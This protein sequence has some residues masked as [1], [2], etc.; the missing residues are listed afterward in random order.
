MEKSVRIYGEY[1]VLQ[2]K[3]VQ[4]GYGRIIFIWISFRLI[5]VSVVT[6][7]NISLQSNEIEIVYHSSPYTSGS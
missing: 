7:L 3:K 1:V 5:S 6:V 2:L 4:D